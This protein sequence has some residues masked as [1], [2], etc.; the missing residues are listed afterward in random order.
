MQAAVKTVQA[1]RKAVAAALVSSSV[2][3]APGVFFLPS[4]FCFAGCIRPT[5]LNTC[6]PRCFWHTSPSKTPIDVEQQRLM[7][8]YRAA[9]LTF[10]VVAHALIQHPILFVRLGNRRAS[11]AVRIAEKEGQLQ[12]RPVLEQRRALLAFVAIPLFPRLRA[13][14]GPAG[15]VDGVLRADP[16]LRSFPGRTGCDLEFRFELRE[17]FHDFICRRGEM[18]WMRGCVDA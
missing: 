13:D 10:A 1:G 5:I 12:I 15:W 11:V 6:V 16:L 17:D 8:R 7:Y 4:F 3:S 14:R 2:L 18:R 9:H